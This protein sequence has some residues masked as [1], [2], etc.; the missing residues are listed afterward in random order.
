MIKNKYGWELAPAYD[1]LNV[2]IVLPDDT[3]ELALTLAGKKRNF[4]RLH[5]EQFGKELGLTE[6][7]IKR[8]FDRLFKNKS[9]ALQ[10][11]ELSFLSEEMKRAYVNM[12]DKRYGQLA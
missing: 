6:I 4:K 3:E 2:S 12:L 9:K 10:W 7:Q 5:F 8:S 1:L 11:I